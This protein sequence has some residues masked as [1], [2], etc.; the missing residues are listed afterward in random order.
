MHPETP[1][2]RLVALF[3]LNATVD[4]CSG[5]QDRRLHRARRRPCFRHNTVQPARHGGVR[6]D[7]HVRRASSGARVARHHCGKCLRIRDCR[8]EGPE[9][10]MS[11]LARRDGANVVWWGVSI[12]GGLFGC[13]GSGG[14]HVGFGS[15]VLVFLGCKWYPRRA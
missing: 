11:G 6:V 10:H 14:E 5:L 12:G 13:Q 1:Y 15:V 7:V 8:W 2:R 9:I 3:D 4:S